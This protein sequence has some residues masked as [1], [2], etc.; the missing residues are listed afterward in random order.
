MGVDA[1]AEIAAG[2]LAQTG[3]GG[4]MLF[5]DAGQVDLVH[6]AERAEPAQAFAR[7]AATEL[8]A[9][10]HVVEREGFL[11]AEKEA[12]NFT[13][14]TGQ[15]KRSEDVNKK[16]DGLELK[17][18]ERRWRRYLE[19]FF[20]SDSR[21]FWFFFRQAAAFGKSGVFYR[22]HGKNIVFHEPL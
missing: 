22:W 6:G 5:A 16:R 4:E 12:V 20:P 2:E 11:R 9:G 10:L 8:Q 7:G 18:A 19:I 17:G 21:G 13:D 14:G 1:V 15:R 3:L